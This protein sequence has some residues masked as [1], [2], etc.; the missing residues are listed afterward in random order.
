MLRYITIEMRKVLRLQNYLS[1]KSPL[2]IVFGEPYKISNSKKIIIPFKDQL[3][4]QTPIMRLENLLE[5]SNGIYCAEFR[6][7]NTLKH[8]MLR[9]F[10]MNLDLNLFQKLYSQSTELFK[11]SDGRSI[12]FSK[13]VIRDNFY[14]AMRYEDSNNSFY[15][16]LIITESMFDSLKEQ[17]E[18]YL[19][20]QIENIHFHKK[21]FL[22]NLRLDSYQLITDESETEDEDEDEEEVE[23]KEEEI[24]VTQND[25]TNEE[26]LQE[27]GL[28][29]EGEGDADTSLL[30]TQDHL[31]PEAH[32][33]EQLKEDIET[34]EMSQFLEMKQSLQQKMKEI[35]LMTNEIQAI[36]GKL[37]KKG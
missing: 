29:D 12:Q 26:I 33:S 24:H 31:S 36:Y 27:S 11:S 3:F 34:D 7:Q 35:D 17:E 2:P 30:Q 22:S 14:P 8:T 4:F 5:L 28:Q 18:Y 21:L 1:K 15:L 23:Q 6:I 32:D 16:Q 20:I 9:R 10:L 19:F 37:K 13:E 25:K